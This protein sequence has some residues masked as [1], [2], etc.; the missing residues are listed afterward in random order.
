MMTDWTTA[1]LPVLAEALRNATLPVHGYL[2]ELE[3]VFAAREPEVLAFVP[4]AGRFARL[5]AEADAL[6]SRWPDPVTRPALFGVPVGV[7]DIF[8]VAGFVTR[9]GTQVPAEVLQGAEGPVVRALREAGALILG[10]TVTT[11]FAYFGPGPTRNPHTLAHTPGGSSSGSAA[12]VAA[13]LSPLTFGTQTVGSIIR[14]AAFC[15]VV[16][17]KPSYEAL[18][19]EGVIPLAPSADHVGLFAA[20]VAGAAYAAQ[21]LGAI[22]RVREVT[23]PVLAIANGAYLARGSQ[24]A[25]E[26]LA[27]VRARLTAAGMTVL[28]VDVFADFDRLADLH[29]DLVAAE[30]ADVHAAWYGAYGHLYHPKT[31]ALIAHGRKVSAERLQMGR[32]SR[33]QVREMVMQQMDAMRIDAWLAPSAV[34]AAPAGL[35]STGDPVMNL[36]WTH[37]GL[38]VVG[39]PSGKT[40]TGLPLGVQLAGRFGADDAVFGVALAVEQALAEVTSRGLYR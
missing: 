7:K 21:V 26:N 9:A 31:A 39:L 15:G 37:A 11:E 36:P 4:E 6:L 38:P 23:S 40:A 10:K 24:A 13:G 1:S 29:N 18:S 19:R 20:D 25:R 22:A 33:R 16:G 34:G 2:T 17:Y 14:P 30:A 32:E 28:E 5:R 12:A 8:H 3:A 35:D 27:V